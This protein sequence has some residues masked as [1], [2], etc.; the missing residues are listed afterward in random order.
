MSVIRSYLNEEVIKKN[1]SKAKKQMIWGVTAIAFYSAAFSGVKDGSLE[2]YYIALI[3]VLLLPHFYLVWCARRNYNMNSL[4]QKYNKIFT[5][6]RN[7][8]ITASEMEQTIGKKYF[9]IFIELEMLFRNGYFVNCTLQQGRNP[10]VIINNAQAG[11]QKGIGFMQMVCPKCGGY[12]RIRANSAG[13]CEFCGSDIR[14]PR[15]ESK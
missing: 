7:G 12:T 6:D 2:G 14:A 10:S 4:A 9:D 5:S 15:M 1:R 3:I 13:Q 11:D 8:I